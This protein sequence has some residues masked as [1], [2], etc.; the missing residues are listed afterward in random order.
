MQAG[1]ATQHASKP[2]CGAVELAASQMVC[3]S[4][5]DG[6]VGVPVSDSGVI[7]VMLFAVGACV[8]AHACVC[9]HTCTHMCGLGAAIHQVG[10]GCP[11]CGDPY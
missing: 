4:P 11:E 5:S 3:G 2:L 6:S 9:A 10:L 8:R 1:D 7:R